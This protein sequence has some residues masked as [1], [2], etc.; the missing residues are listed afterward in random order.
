MNRIFPHAQFV[1]ARAELK[2]AL[3]NSQRGRFIFVIG[4]SGIGKTTVRQA[5]LRAICGNPACWGEG[6]IP[7]I[8][9]FALLAQ[10]AYFNS[11]S[12]A[13][14]LVHELIAPN[15]RW[16]RDNDD[17]ANPLYVTVKG[18][19]DRAHR[20][21]LG[22]PW[23][24]GTE[25]SMWQ[26]FQQ[27]AASR[28]MWLAAID[29]AHALC[30]NHRNKDPADHILNL[31]SILDG[32][33]LNF[34]LSGVHGVADLWAQRPEVR[35]RST[36]IWMRPYSYE[37]REDRDPFLILLRTLGAEYSFSRPALLFEMAAELM[38]ASAGIFGV[39]SK[40]LADAKECADR[41][42]RYAIT[43]NDITGSYYGERD[44]EKMWEDVKFFETVMRSANTKA[45]AVMVASTWG[46][47]KKAS[48]VTGDNSE[49]TSQVDSDG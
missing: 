14:S 36:L 3:E 7:V 20:E 43:K 47:R 37:R 9:V 5:I 32:G 13:E 31:M 15:P 18:E 22:V 21:L 10:R 24:K 33:D 17:P 6:R 19:I 26:L 44:Y 42:G 2:R 8:E 49:T 48:T 34:L 35:R 46:L 25:R 11:R 39:L 23:P 29:Q 28:G 45:R 41:A 4:P 1:G 12:L 30:T 38:A 40:I 27:L 16:L